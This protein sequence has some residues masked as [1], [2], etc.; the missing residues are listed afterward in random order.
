MSSRR[1]EG[2]PDALE[3]LGGGRHQKLREGP[4][5]DFTASQPQEAGCGDIRLGNAAV[6]VDDEQRD[7]GVR[8]RRDP[9]AARPVR[10][11]ALR[12]SLVA[13]L[14]TNGPSPPISFAA[15]HR[16]IGR[17]VSSGRLDPGDLSGVAK[18][19]QANAG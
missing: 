5:N 12:Y 11:S 2:L 13:E 17:C 10:A 16:E 3:A 19:G 6:V 15:R 14:R 1:M 9:L 18:A 4:P 8:D 7:R